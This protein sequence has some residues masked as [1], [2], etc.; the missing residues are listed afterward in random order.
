MTVTESAPKETQALVGGAKVPMMGTPGV[1]LQEEQAAWGTLTVAPM[2]EDPG[3]LIRRD[4]KTEVGDYR[5]FYA[6]VRDA[7]NGDAPL[8]VSSEDGFARLKDTGRSSGHYGAPS[9]VTRRWSYRRAKA[10]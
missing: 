6:S 8:A 5:G 1:W 4:V 7:I 2:P 3:N 10:A 9:G